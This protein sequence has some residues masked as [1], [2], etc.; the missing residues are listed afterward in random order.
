MPYAQILCDS[1]LGV[2]L[3]ERYALLE[4]MGSWLVMD[5]KYKEAVRI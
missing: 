5:G 3:I 4:K 2:D 1:N